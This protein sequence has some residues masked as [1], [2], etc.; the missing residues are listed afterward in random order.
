MLEILQQRA[1]TEL[2]G[3]KIHAHANG[4]QTFCTPPSPRLARG[5]QYPPAGF[6][7]DGTFA[8]RGDECSPRPKPSV[9]MLPAKQSFGPDPGAVARSYLA[10][11]RPDEPLVY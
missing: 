4:G 7:R 6:Y 10:L 5:R 1:V 2:G 9:P 8:E 3:K 11:V